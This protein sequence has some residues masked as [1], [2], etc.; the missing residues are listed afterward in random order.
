MSFLD[1]VQAPRKFCD[2]RDSGWEM[3]V[4][5]EGTIPKHPLRYSQEVSPFTSI[6]YVIPAKSFR[7]KIDVCLRRCIIN[8]T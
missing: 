5:D 6:C 4:W 2:S 8:C 1:V 7:T 3:A